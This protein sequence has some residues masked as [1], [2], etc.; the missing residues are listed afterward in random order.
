MIDWNAWKAG[1]RRCC[2]YIENPAKLDTVARCALYDQTAARYIAEMTAELEEMKAYRQALFGRMQT[3]Y[4]TPRRLK[5]TLKREKRYQGNVYYF[6]CYWQEYIEADIPPE[7]VSSTK[8]PGTERAQ[9]I[10]DYHQALRT[11]PGVSC[12]MDIAKSPYER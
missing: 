6:L 9:A 12:E 8:Y 11:H 4:S 5:I 3:L 1:E 10:K 7:L 2:A